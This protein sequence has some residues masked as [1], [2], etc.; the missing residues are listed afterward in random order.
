MLKASFAFGIVNIFFF[1]ITFILALFLHPAPLPNGPGRRGSPDHLKSQ[2]FPKSSKSP[3]SSNTARGLQG[4]GLPGR[5]VNT[6]AIYLIGHKPEDKS[7]SPD[8]L[9]RIADHH[10]IAY[11]MI[12]SEGKLYTFI[13]LKLLDVPFLDRQHFLEDE[14]GVC[15]NYSNYL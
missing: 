14:R 6:P 4:R 5:H 8:Q 3:P 13:L 12:K 1:F 15:K 2:K 11:I 10:S 9:T 7:L